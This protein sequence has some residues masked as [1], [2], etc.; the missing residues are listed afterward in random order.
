ML[1]LRDLLLQLRK[2]E[3]IKSTHRSSGRHK[4]IIRAL[5]ELADHE[6]WLANTTSVPSEAEIQAVWNTR[7]VNPE[8]KAHPLDLLNSTTSMGLFFF[9]YSSSFRWTFYV[10]ACLV[11]PDNYIYLTLRLIL[12]M[13]D[14][15]QF[16]QRISLQRQVIR[17]RIPAVL[18][19]SLN[20]NSHFYICFCLP[21]L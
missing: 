5:K 4:T 17:H 19:L 3:S 6:G 7:L 18:A 21:C 13:M 14:L 12:Y 15:F 8:S 2:G 11:Y 9:S 10:A 16:S 20:L 1:E